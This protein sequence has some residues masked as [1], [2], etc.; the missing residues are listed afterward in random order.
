MTFSSLLLRCGCRNIKLEITLNGFTYVAS[1]VLLE[2]DDC[3]VCII[4][5]MSVGL[6]VSVFDLSLSL[7]LSLSFPLSLSLIHT[8]HLITSYL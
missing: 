1:H 7:S 4:I 3:K 6:L 5:C 8:L 2:I